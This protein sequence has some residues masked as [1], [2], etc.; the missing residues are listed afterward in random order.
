[1]GLLTQEDPIGIAGGLNLYGYANGD[2]INF[3]DPFGL[4]PDPVSSFWIWA[5]KNHY[6]RA[7]GNSANGAPSGTPGSGWD[8]Q[9]RELSAFHGRRNTKYLSSDKRFEAVLRPDGSPETDPAL[10]A[11]ENYGTN[12]WSHSVFDIAPW[13]LF[14]NSPQDPSTRAE[15]AGAAWNGFQ[16]L[17]GASV[18]EERPLLIKREND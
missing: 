7:Q 8:V 9:S 2:P 15:R 3:S 14:G 13:V 17:F 1:M 12:R 18:P 4:D 16:A 10:L 6:G 5:V 11:T